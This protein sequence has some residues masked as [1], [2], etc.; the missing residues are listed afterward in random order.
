MLPT[1]K[2]NLHIQLIPELE[3]CRLSTMTAAET[4]EKERKAA[5][6]TENRESHSSIIIRS[7]GRGGD[8]DFSLVGIM[9]Q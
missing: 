4:E 8:R 5:I 1:S 7:F 2:V 9:V 3:V 6:L